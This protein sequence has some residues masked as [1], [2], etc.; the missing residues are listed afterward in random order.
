MS[1]KS[2]TD[3]YRGENIIVSPD[4]LVVKVND[5][6]IA[7]Y[8]DVLYRMKIDGFLISR[9]R[10]E[11]DHL[12][13]IG[14]TEDG[15]IYISELTDDEMTDEEFDEYYIRKDIP[16]EDRFENNIDTS[17]D[18]ESGFNKNLTSY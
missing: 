2:Y 13:V 18:F 1:K 9:E 6:E 15:D 16:E 17:G 11:E 8:P 12:K 4:N 14:K 7:V 5:G 3:K 10:D